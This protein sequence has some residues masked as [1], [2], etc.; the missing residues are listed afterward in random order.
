MPLVP[1]AVY[2]LLLSFTVAWASDRFD[3]RSVS[4]RLLGFALVASF[5]TTPTIVEFSANTLP[6][7]LALFGSFACAVMACNRGKF[8]AVGCVAL[9]AVT[10]SMYQSSAF[11]ML[12]LAL[13]LLITDTLR[14]PQSAG[15]LT[16]EVARVVLLWLLGVG[17]Y[18]LVSQ[19]FLW[20]F[21]R[22]IIY[23]QNYFAPRLLFEQP[24]FVLRAIWD[25]GT[26][27]FLGRWESGFLPVP[28]MAPLTVTAGLLTL[29]LLVRRFASHGALLLVSLVLL[30]G[31]VLLPFAMHFI[32]PVKVPYR[33]MLAA[34]FV[35]WML[36]VWAGQAVPHRLMGGLLVGLLGL[37][38]L[39]Q[40]RQ[41][42]QFFFAA[43]LVSWHDRIVATRLIDRVD[44]VLPPA[45]RA[46]DCPIPMIIG[47]ELP[48]EN[49]RSFKG[50]TAT[51]GSS[52]FE[53]DDGSALRIAAYLHLLGLGNFVAA[54]A[55]TD[56]RL[57]PIMATLQVWPTDGSVRY[58][59][60]VLLVHFA[61]R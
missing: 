55:A 38:V 28:L 20:E 45:A 54:D 21:H 12:A 44:R 43:E 22:K 6:T 42:N 15:A 14:A 29:W 5:P 24:M 59:D 40:W 3:L 51:A 25:G 47:G 10:V 7:G 8:A 46:C 17:L 27:L 2:G 4:M 26:R 34:P 35:L 13:G 11:L 31:I 49:G 60:G 1:L 18:V 36:L 39:T 9:L 50:A 33:S 37:V 48:F 61:N 57:R 16:G 32:S 52:F 56:A 53:W 23:I 30:A 19:I 41:V 58:V